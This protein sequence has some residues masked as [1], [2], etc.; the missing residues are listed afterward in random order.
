MLQLIREN[1]DYHS[2][3]KQRRNRQVEVNAEPTKHPLNPSGR[4][5]DRPPYQTCCR[6]PSARRRATSRLSDLRPQVVRRR[7]RQ[8]GR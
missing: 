3:P 8:S 7:R 1:L 4:P 2:V 5:C 6:G